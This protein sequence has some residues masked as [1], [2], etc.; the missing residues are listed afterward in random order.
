M[1]ISGRMMRKIGEARRRVGTATVVTASGEER[2]GMSRTGFEVGRKREGRDAR[3]R[4]GVRAQA[5]ETATVTGTRSERGRLEANHPVL[6]TSRRRMKA[7]GPY[8]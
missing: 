7:Q 1:R 3:R 2:A 8:Q 5:T 4:R 6:R